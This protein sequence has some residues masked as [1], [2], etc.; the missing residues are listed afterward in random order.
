MPLKILLIDDDPASR[1][2]MKEILAQEDVTLATETDAEESARLI[3]H[4]RYEGIF[5]NFGTQGVDA[6]G[7]SR[8]IRRSDA[9]RTTPIVMIARKSD[10]DALSRG[11]KAGATFFLPAPVTRHKVLEVLRKS[12]GTMM[13]ERR[14]M[15]RISFRADITCFVAG[16]EFMGHTLDLSETGMAVEIKQKLAGG[17]Q[18]RSV[19]QL[20]PD[21]LIESEMVVRVVHRHRAGVEFTRISTEDR[22][23]IRDHVKSA[24]AD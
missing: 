14:R 5:L 1:E 3:T 10:A 7:L 6:E 18:M 17:T 2:L 20:T 21:R 24:A 15:R 16:Q 23:A 11:F 8:K 4:H 13:V 12:R 22:Q 19:F 9:N